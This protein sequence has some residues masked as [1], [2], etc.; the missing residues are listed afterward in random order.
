MKKI[1]LLFCML[2]NMQIISAQ[3]YA[4][5]LEYYVLSDGMKSTNAG[6]APVG[7]VFYFTFNSNKSMCYMTD[8]NGNYNNGYGIGKYKYIGC[9]NNMYIFEECGTMDMFKDLLYFSKDFNRMNW[10]C[11]LD[12]LDNDE[13]KTR[14]LIYTSSPNRQREQSHL[15]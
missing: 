15:Y 12:N 3:T 10:H 11:N 14:V 13:D 8:K 6:G 7:T 4:Y 9:R 2:L 5:I 1:F